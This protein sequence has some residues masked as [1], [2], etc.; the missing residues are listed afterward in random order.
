MTLMY[1]EVY[2][3]TFV[4]LGEYRMESVAK[5]PYLSFRR[6]PE[7]S[8]LNYFLDSGLRRNDKIINYIQFFKGL[9]GVKI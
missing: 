7:S 2:I 8:I 9:K 5:L 1:G 3:K 6:R 4:M